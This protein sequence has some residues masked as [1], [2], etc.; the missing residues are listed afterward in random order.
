MRLGCPPQDH[1]EIGVSSTGS[2][3]DWGVLPQEIGVSSTASRWDWGVLH[4]IIRRLGCPPQDHHKIRVSLHKRIMMRLGCPY[5]DHDEIGGVSTCMDHEIVVS[6]SGPWW[7]R[8]V[9][10][11]I[12]M[13][14]GCPQMDHDEIGV[15]PSGSWWDRGVDL[16]EKWERGVP[17]WIKHPNPKVPNLLDGSGYDL[18]SLRY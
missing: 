9:P 8:C 14:L 12:M 6:P 16:D 5:V 7:E 11:W 1:D 4:R 15:S 13:R 2:W 10:T 18:F 17:K 3:W